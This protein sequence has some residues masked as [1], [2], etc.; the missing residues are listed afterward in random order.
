MLVD[1]AYRLEKYAEMNEKLFAM[2]SA[3]HLV[4][5]QIDDKEYRLKKPIERSL[6]ENWH[7]MEL[8]MRKFDRIFNRVEKFDARKFNDFENH[9]RREKIMLE[10]MRFRTVQ[11]YT[12]FTGKLTEEEQQYRDYF[13]TDLELYPEDSELEEQMD[14]EILSNHPDMNPNL[15][16][17]CD[18][19]KEGEIHENYDDIIEDKVF[20]YK[21]RINADDADTY[22]RRS[23]RQAQRWRERMEHRDPSIHADL[24][25]RYQRDWKDTSLGQIMLDHEQSQ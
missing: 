5:K 24:V 22:H 4:G 23:V 6:Y 13:E 11:N 20:K 3:F 7:A 18:M 8:S 15:W 21:Y 25:E 16:D 14:R 10:K 19:Y 12:Y 2:H 17:F 9:E 1:P